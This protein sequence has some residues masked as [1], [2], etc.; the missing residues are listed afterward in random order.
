MNIITINLKY[1]IFFALNLIASCKAQDIQNLSLQS[2]ADMYRG[3]YG[4]LQATRRTED[5]I[6]KNEL[7]VLPQDSDEYKQQEANLL[8]TRNSITQLESDLSNIE[9]RLKA[10]VNSVSPAKLQSFLTDTKGR[11]SLY[12]RGGLRPILFIRSSIQEQSLS[13]TANYSHL[14]NP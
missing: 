3:T 7:N 11:K 2:L 1:C 10:K 5:W 4:Q 8:D 6:I 14:F 12:G 13:H 9:Q